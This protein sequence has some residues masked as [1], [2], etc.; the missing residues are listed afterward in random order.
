MAGTRSLVFVRG[1]GFQM[2]KSRGS[3]WHRHPRM[4]T[5]RKICSAVD[6]QRHDLGDLSN[7]QNSAP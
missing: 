2:F 5:H 3:G 4:P 1:V 7:P 6:G